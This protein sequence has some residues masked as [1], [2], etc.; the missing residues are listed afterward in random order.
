MN[1]NAAPSAVPPE[2]SVIAPVSQ[3]LD[4]VKLVLFQPFDLGKW[5]VIGFCAWLAQLGESGGS[6]NFRVPGDHNRRGGG[7]FEQEFEQAKTFVL[8]NLHWL[9]PVVVAVVLL[10]MAVGVFIT[11]LNSRG[12]F[13]FLHCVALNRADV[14][15]PWRKYAR[16]GNSL[17]WFRILLGLLSSV[18][19]LPLA[20]GL[21]VFAVLTFVKGDVTPVAIAG[22]IGG[23]LVLLVFALVFFLIIKLTVDF[24]VPVMYLRGC[25]W[26]EG[27]GIMRRRLGAQVGDL[28]LYLLFQ[29]VLAIITGTLVLLL[30]IIT[31]CACC[32]MLLPY[33]GTVLLLPVFVFHRA[34][35][36]HYLAQFGREFDVF[37]PAPGGAGA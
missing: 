14:E 23:V 10:I 27:W 11:W 32:L 30:M 4:R 12:K 31:C 22:F 20:A 17:F 35:S 37:A 36:L 5:F 13:M 33:L 19:M 6:Y 26:Q 34:Y 28:L 9:I 16:P 25:G 1:T 7:G 18:V 21:A 3:A 29:F 8:D 24:V 2:I 15:V